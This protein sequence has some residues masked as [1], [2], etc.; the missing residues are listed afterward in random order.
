MT[1]V[2]DTWHFK[3]I[4]WKT[5]KNKEVQW[6]FALCTETYDNQSDNSLRVNWTCER[7]LKCSTSGTKK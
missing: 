7:D 5:L 6:K 3:T 1:T 2:S 4:N